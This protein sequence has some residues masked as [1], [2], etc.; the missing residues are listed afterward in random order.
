VQPPAVEGDLYS[1]GVLYANMGGE[2][3]YSN[4]AEVCFNLTAK[5]NKSS[6]LIKLTLNF[7]IAAWGLQCPAGDPRGREAGGEI[8]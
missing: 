7:F 8:G 1:N 5:K 3:M 4:V 2:P 6:N